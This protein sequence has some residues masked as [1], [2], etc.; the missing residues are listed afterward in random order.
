V[1]SPSYACEV[2]INLPSTA[3]VKAK[4]KG[5]QSETDQTKRTRVGSLERRVVDLRHHG[6]VRLL[7]ILVSFFIVVRVVAMIMTAVFLVGILCRGSC[8]LRGR[9]T[10]RHLVQ[11][12]IVVK[13]RN[14]W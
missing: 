5:S 8:P 13:M 11:V 1:Y 2:V 7:D 6:L 4:N 3:L 12:L 14:E 10:R 9:S